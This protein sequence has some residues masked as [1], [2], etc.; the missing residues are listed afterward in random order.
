MLSDLFHLPAGEDV[1]LSGAVLHGRPV[2][3]AHRQV[4]SEVR[5]SL[6]PEPEVRPFEL[7]ERLCEAVRILRQHSHDVRDNLGLQVLRGKN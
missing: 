7:Q 3:S 2:G 6:C 4:Q 5:N 1:R